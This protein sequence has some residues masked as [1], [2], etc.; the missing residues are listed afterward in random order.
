MYTQCPECEALFEITATDLAVAGGFVR[1]GQCSVSFDALNS[2][3]DTP[4]VADD[5]EVAV[6]PAPDIV[7]PV[8]PETEVEV[9]KRVVESLSQERDS[10]DEDENAF[11]VIDDDDDDEEILLDDSYEPPQEDEEQEIYAD[12][13]FSATEHDDTPASELE[14]E[15]DNFEIFFGVD[16]L[17]HLTAA[18]DTTVQDE[19]DAEKVDASVLFSLPLPELTPLDHEQRGM[20]P[21]KLEGGEAARDPCAL[22][23]STTKHKIA[24]FDTA[25][26]TR[27][28]AIRANDAIDAADARDLKHYLGGSKNRAVAA[29]WAGGSV[30]MALL[31]AGQIIHRNRGDLMIHPR[32]GPA[33]SSLYKVVGVNLR[34]N[35][36]IRDYKVVGQARLFEMPSEVV[37]GE[38]A[39]IALRFVTIITNG[40]KQPQPAPM[41]RLTLRDRW[42]DPTGIRDFAPPEYLADR[43]L[44]GRLLEPGQRLRVVLNIADPGTDVVGFDFDMCLPDGV[45]TLRCA[46]EP[47]S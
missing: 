38:S 33:V 26:P 32:L 37:A 18:D 17:E 14:G 23:V 39:A 40:A 6:E 15:D 4:E 42:G 11:V 2:L 5:A 47:A 35:W 3:R 28:K 22:T 8:A 21:E 27:S 46:N 24:R 19:S 1:C 12:S 13:K 30:L 25:K 44:I 16:E 36:Q 10:L 29:A 45:G 34:P 31:L 43:T 20:L 41:V 7:D 9:A